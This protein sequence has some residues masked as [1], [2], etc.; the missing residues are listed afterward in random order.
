MTNTKEETTMT[1]TTSGEVT[2][3]TTLAQCAA[4]D[5]LF[6]AKAEADSKRCWAPIR[7][8]QPWHVRCCKLPIGHD[9]Q[10]QV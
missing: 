4:I 7:G 6:L 9:G 1:K 10:H 3:P 2:G 8:A 5:A